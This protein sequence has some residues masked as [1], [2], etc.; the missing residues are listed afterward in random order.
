MAHAHE[1][2]RQLR[3]LYV[4]KRLP[5]EQACHAAGVPAGTG[6]RWRQEAKAKGDDWDSHRSA[7]ALGDDNQKALACQLLEEYLVQHQ[8]VMQR[9]AEAKDMAPAEHAR[10]LMGLM[11]AFNKAMS[12]FKKLSP[13]LNRHAV[14]LDTLQRLATFAQQRYPQHV[15]ALLEMLEPF[16]E[17]LA[18]AY[19]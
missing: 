18:K 1:K 3:G 16:G 12:S 5:L 10:I 14:A 17:E 11:D 8:A 2:R 6:K 13:E 9:L 15:G 4:Y 7:I 19:G